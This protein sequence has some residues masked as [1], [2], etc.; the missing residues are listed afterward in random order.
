MLSNRIL[1]PIVTEVFNRGEIPNK[2]EPQPNGFNHSSETDFRYFMNLYKNALQNHI[3][4]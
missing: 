2:A 1:N 3:L 4:F